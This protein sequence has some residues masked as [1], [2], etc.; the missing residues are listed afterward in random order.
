[1]YVTSTELKV[2]LSKYLGLAAKEDI[3]ITKNGEPIAKIVLPKQSIVEELAGCAKLN[4]RRDYKE[5]IR[6][7]RLKRY[8]NID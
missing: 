5:V 6:E 4:D 1:M 2:N 3:F 7:E 8:E